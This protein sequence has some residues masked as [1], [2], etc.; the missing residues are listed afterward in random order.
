[1]KSKPSAQQNPNKILI[2]SPNWIGDQILSYP[3]FY[4]L[5]K[6]YPKSQIAVSCVPW[7]RD[8]QF[9]NLINEV[10]VL[11]RPENP[12]LLAKWK[13]L[14]LGAEALRKEGPWDLGICLPN[15]FSSAWLLYRA[16]VARRRGY[17]ADGRGFLLHESLPWTKGD[18][19]SM[20]KQVSHRSEAYAQLLPREIQPI[21]NA[22]EFWGVYPLN[23]LDPKIPGVLNTFE[24]EKEWPQGPDSN[25]MSPPAE[26]YWVLAPGTTAESRRWPASQFATLARRVADET[27]WT[28]VIVGGAAEGEVAKSLTE[29]SSLKLL[30][31]TAKGVVTSYSKIFQQAQFTVCNDSGLAH[32]ASLC[33]S[34]VYV[35]WGAGNP[36][37][38]EPIGPGKVNVIMNPVECWPCESNICS[39]VPQKRL[40]C[41]K[42]IS[43]DDVWKEIKAGTANLNASPK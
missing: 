43:A 39:Q 25:V 9:R 24:V 3:F 22:Q 4:H 23:E 8:V 26:K 35:V 38:T 33:G 7:V 21:P 34:S 41:L 13:A 19:I 37:R 36:K 28:G 16:K 14:E 15:S 10:Y 32:L 11:P 5:R 29:N 17:S 31:W 2:R 1:M 12:S 27:G 42:G 30:D 40:G 6:A 18:P 20:G